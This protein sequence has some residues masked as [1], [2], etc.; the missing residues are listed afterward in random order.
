MF[1]SLQGFLNLIS[2]LSLNVL[3]NLYLGQTSFVVVGFCLQNVNL[4]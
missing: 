1:V 2:M 4:G 3:W